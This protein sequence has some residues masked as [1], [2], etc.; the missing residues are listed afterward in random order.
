MSKSSIVLPRPWATAAG[1]GTK[2]IP[3]PSEAAFTAIFGTILPPASYLQTPHGKAAYYTIPPSTAS[4]INHTN[5]ISRILLIHGVQ[6]CAIGLQ[7]LAIALSSRFPGAQIVLFDLWGHGLT[8]TPIAPHEP[9]LFHAL[10]KALMA[11]LEWERAHFLGYSFGGSTTASFA[12]LCPE[13]VASMV[14]LAPAG[15]W[16]LELDEVQARYMTGGDEELEEAARTWIVQTLEGG[17]LVVPADWKERVARGEVVAEAVRD[18]EM[19]VH[20]GHA[21]SVVG[22]FRDGGV[23]GKEAEFAEAAKRGTRSLCILGELDDLCTEQDLNDVGFLN[24]KVVPQVGHGI[25][26]QKVQEVAK[27]VEAFWN[28]IS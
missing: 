11:K 22:I 2:S 7:P 26:R 17:E 28:E 10:I 21:A 20:E 3:A 24:V 18:W 19:R 5:P 9:A 15:L 27:L 25:P 13:M 14:L 4:P 6:T 1:K 8:D 12:A 23:R 16:R